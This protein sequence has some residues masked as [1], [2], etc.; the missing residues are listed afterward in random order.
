MVHKV[1]S[2]STKFNDDL[3]VPNIFSIADTFLSRL[4]N[5]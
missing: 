5:G 3:F 4:D 1:F 2:H